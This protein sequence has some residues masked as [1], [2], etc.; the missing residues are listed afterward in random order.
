VQVEDALVVDPP[1][2]EGPLWTV[3][4]DVLHPTPR[5]KGAMCGG[6]D[7][8]MILGI[9]PSSLS[10]FGRRRSS[11]ARTPRG[12]PAVLFP[13]GLPPTRPSL[14]GR[15]NRDIFTGVPVKKDPLPEGVRPG[16]GD[17]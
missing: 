10:D 14:C 9:S 11:D 13:D 15:R 17:R 4:R 7:L 5:R 3:Q 1:L 6:R 2:D 12:D 16:R 8:H